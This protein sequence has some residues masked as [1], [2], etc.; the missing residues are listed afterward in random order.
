MA[1]VGHFCSHLGVLP[2][3]STQRWDQASARAVSSPEAH[4]SSTVLFLLLRCLPGIQLLEQLI[5]VSNVRAKPSCAC[6]LFVSCFSPVP[7]VVGG[8][9]SQPSPQPPQGLNLA[10][11]LRRVVA[12]PAQPKVAVVP[13]GISPGGRA[14]CLLGAV[15]VL[16]QVCG[17]WAQLQCLVSNRERMECVRH[18]AVVS[19]GRGAGAQLRQCLAK[20][21]PLGL[22]RKEGENPS[23]L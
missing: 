11:A 5:S 6:S 17:A 13:G 20:K 12:Q 2:L 15:G 18:G 3:P 22:E 14:V 1:G 4:S 7:A 10:E 16:A 21:Q 23:S 19:A 9:G 8:S